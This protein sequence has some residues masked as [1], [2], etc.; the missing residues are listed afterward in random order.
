[1]WPAPR[2]VAQ[3]ER[4]TAPFWQCF[5]QEEGNSWPRS[6]VQ[7]FCSSLSVHASYCSTLTSQPCL[8]TP[9]RASLLRCLLAKTNHKDLAKFCL[10][11]PPQ[12]NVPC[13]N[14]R[15]SFWLFRYLT[16]SCAYC[17]VNFKRFC[18][19]D[20]IS[21]SHQR[22]MM[23]HVEGMMAVVRLWWSVLCTFFLEGYPKQK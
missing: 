8:S 10:R 21:V 9:V 1:M 18:C 6:V 11:P 23:R 16:A 15:S 19:T 13:C 20:V 4:V 22:R 17:F 2:T 12:A 5:F 3:Q 14:P 7:W